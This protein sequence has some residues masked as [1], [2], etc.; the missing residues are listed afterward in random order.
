MPIEDWIR[1]AARATWKKERAPR[2]ALESHKPDFGLFRDLNLQMVFGV[3]LISVLGVASVAPLFPAIAKD[4]GI[5]PARVSWLITAFTLP[6]VF[7]PPFLG[8]MTDRVGRK[9]VL[10]PA[11]FLFALAGSA[12][13]FTRDFETL[14]ALRFLQGMGAAPLSGLNVT[15]VGDLYKGHKRVDALGFN[16][17]VLSVGTAVYPALGG[18]LGLLGWHTPFLLPLLAIPVGLGSIFILKLPPL[19]AS[20]PPL[21]AYLL[22]AARMAKDP[23]ILG[24]FLASTSTFVILYGSFH[25]YLPILMAARFNV[26]SLVIGLMASSMS[27]SNAVLASQAGRLGRIYGERSVLRTSFILFALALVLIPLMPLLPLLLIPTLIYGCAQGMNIPA[28][29]ALLSDLAPEENRAVFMSLNGMVLRLGQTLG[30]LV[31][32]WVYVAFGPEAPLYAG[33]LLGLSLFAVLPFM[34]RERD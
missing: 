9:A 11:L 26:S 31:M 22:Q 7:L 23:R 5:S 1:K 10:V 13:A 15:L 17:S 12:C 32:G 33:A 28:T 30:P 19:P 4:L 14:I 29:Q 34:V 18:A 2:E 8:V 24:I 21:K 20:K 16:A 25:T 3:T 6:G 27:V